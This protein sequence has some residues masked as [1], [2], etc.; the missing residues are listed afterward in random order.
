MP[1]V[2]FFQVF[3]GTEILDG[4]LSSFVEK[5]NSQNV[6]KCVSYGFLHTFV[7]VGMLKKSA[8]IYKNATKK[9]FLIK[10][11]AKMDK[12]NKEK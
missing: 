6:K 3:F 11:V 12:K 4:F 1:S 7:R 2:V 10:K 9:R 5:N 8:D